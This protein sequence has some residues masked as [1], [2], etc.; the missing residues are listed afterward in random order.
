MSL[1]KQR[2]LSELGNVMNQLQ[3]ADCGCMGKLF[4]NGGQGGCAGM[5]NPLPTCGGCRRGCCQG[6]GFGA[7]Y[8][9]MP[10]SGEPYS[11]NAGGMTCGGMPP[12]GMH[13]GMNDGMHGG[14]PGGIDGGMH[15]GMSGGM[16]GG[17]HGGMPGGMHGGMPGGMHGGMP[18]GMPGGMHGGMPGG[19]PGGM[20]GRMRGMSRNGIQDG[21]PSGFGTR[22]S[23]M[24]FGMKGRNAQMMY[25]DTYN[26]LNKNLMQPTMQEVYEDL[27][28]IT[29][30][31]TVAANP[32]ATQMGLPAPGGMNAGASGM[33]G[34]MPGGMDMPG[35][36]SN[37]M[38][39]GLGA[40]IVNMMMSGG[41]GRPLNMPQGGPLKEPMMIDAPHS[42][43]GKLGITP[44]AAGGNMEMPGMNPGT[45]AGQPN[46]NMGGMPGNPATMMAN[47]TVQYV[48]Q[49]NMHEVNAMPQGSAM[50]QQGMPQGGA[51]HQGH[52]IQQSN[53][54]QQGQAMQ[55]GNPMSQG[56]HM[57]QG[58][59]MQQGNS[60]QP[61]Q[62]MPQSNVA[63]QNTPGMMV[64]MRQQGGN[65]YG[66]HATGIKKFNEMFPGVMQGDL[67]FDPMAIALQMNPANQKQVAIDTMTKLMNGNRGQAMMP[68]VLRGTNAAIQ[69]LSASQSGQQIQG[70]T[71]PGQTPG[72]ALQPNQQQVYATHTGA[73]VMNQQMTPQQ[74]PLQQIQGQQ[75]E[76]GQQ[77][78]DPNTGAS[79]EETEGDPNAPQDGAPEIEEGSADPTKNTIA[80]NMTPQYNNFQYNTLG[81]P[82]SL[83][84][85]TAFHS[86]GPGLPQTLDGAYRGN[87]QNMNVKNT[88]SKT[89]IAGTIPVGA[90]ASRSQLQHIYRHA[91][92][93]QNMKSP[94]Q[95]GSASVGNL[96]AANSNMRTNAAPTQQIP[97]DV[98]GDSTANN[99]EQPNMDQA[100]KQVSEA[101]AP[102]SNAPHGDMILEKSPA[103]VGKQRNG[104]Q[105][106]AF[107]AY[108][109]KAAW[110]FHG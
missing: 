68:S 78:I 9:H 52:P 65:P 27:K 95:A 23:G 80:Y 101:P 61:G 12:K 40:N 16:P 56:N 50:P 71:A 87:L 105:D 107:T 104:L 69:Q 39:A 46:G 5:G 13:G 22:N 7:N 57:Q 35:A 49:D 94:L 90:T 37:P 25:S 81:Q 14:M 67:N 43:H 75:L 30:E 41:R 1:D 59:A 60:M 77:Q 11:T 53:P 55:Q 76:Q 8:V 24:P 66:Q 58:Q 20:H 92:A 2:I 42:P 45:G 26:Y 17:M 15:G 31:N 88:V 38:T 44:I 51:M 108:R 93:A 62:A 91:R 83:L 110:S 96:N 6:H 63:P 98:G 74:V 102:T 4:N 64:N 106:L 47:P 48:T 103:T 32:L 85:A 34:Q 33:G 89:A 10:D 18:G 73:P 21:M 99:P 97:E 84:P 100:I 36:Q 72:T 109:G 28:S 54:M 79:V 82:V 3:S 86:R 70:Q 19:M 29:P